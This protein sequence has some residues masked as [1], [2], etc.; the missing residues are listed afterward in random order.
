MLQK[1]DLNELN[2]SVILVTISSD[3]QCIYLVT[4]AQ[5]TAI[6]RPNDLVAH[7]GGEKFICLLPD[8]QHL[9]AMN[10]PHRQ[11]SARFTFTLVSKRSPLT[12]VVRIQPHR[13]LKW[14]T[15]IESAD[16]QSYLAKKYGRNQVS[17]ATLLR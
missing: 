6:H 12:G 11:R 8:T 5:R 17:R 14:Q 9:G 7:Y 16:K 13:H 15:L 2:F 10:I 3:D 1:I 4:K